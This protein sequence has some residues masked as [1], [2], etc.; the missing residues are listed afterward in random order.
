MIPRIFHFVWVGPNEI[1][2]KTK[3]C[4]ASWEKFNPG[5]QLKVW[6][7][8]D[9]RPFLNQFTKDAIRKKKWAFAADFLRLA[10]VYA[11]GGIYLDTDMLALR[12][13]DLNVLQN[14]FFIGEEAANQVSFGIFGAEPNSVVVQFMLK[15]YDGLRFDVFFPPIIPRFLGPKLRAQFPHIY[16]VE[17][18]VFYPL[19]FEC[20]EQDFRIFCTE[21]TVCV[22]LWDHS[23]NQARSRSLVSLV[24][25]LTVDVIIYGYPTAYA[26]KYLNKFIINRLRKTAN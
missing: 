13:F 6:G 25:E 1:P 12:P 17:R 23:W 9:V 3:E 24:T 5:F 21:T 26:K 10:I 20:R 2:A 8:D 7:N 22:H 19:P 4:I 18:S 14:N 11:E 15:Q 16:I